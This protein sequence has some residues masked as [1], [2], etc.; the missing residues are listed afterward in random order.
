MNEKQLHELIIKYAPGLQTLQRT[1]YDQYCSYD[2]FDSKY[3]MEYKCR[4]KWYPDG[5]QLEQ[6]K[7][8]K[9]TNVE[10]K[11]YLYAVYDGKEHIR[12]WN[13]SKMADDG[14]DF[15]W[16]TKMCPSTTDFDRNEY[17]PKTVGILGWDDCL[18]KCKVAPKNAESKRIKPEE[19]NGLTDAE[20]QKRADA[21]AN[22]IYATSGL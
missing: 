10:G 2:A 17:V 7:Y 6:P 12:I 14:Y 4:R 22:H 18:W 11:Q 15:R 19:A 13:V 8:D 21:L 9:N 5:T 16:E 3:V 1:D 20:K